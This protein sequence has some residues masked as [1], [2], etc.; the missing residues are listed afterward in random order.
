MLKSYEKNNYPTFNE[1]P[2]VRLH[3]TYVSLFLANC[4]QFCAFI[5]PDFIA[6]GPID[7]D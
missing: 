6:E 3:P 1:T 5:L 4:R 2:Q 7:I